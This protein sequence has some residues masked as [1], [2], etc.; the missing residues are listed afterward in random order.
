MNK[1][2]KALRD[3][4]VSKMVEGI[5][6]SDEVMPKT[7]MLLEVPIETNRFL[8]KSVEVIPNK[9]IPFRVEFFE[10]KSAI[11]ARYNSGIVTARCYDVLDLPYED[12]DAKG[13]VYFV[14][15]NTSDY[16]ATFTAI[17]R[18]LLLK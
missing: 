8:F 11:L 5:A 2:I 4:T 14:I 13:M 6:T 1:I 9:S 16:A 18:G 15:H 7:S 12:K 10:S 17:A 3:G